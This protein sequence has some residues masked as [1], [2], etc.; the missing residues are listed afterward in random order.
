MTTY[1]RAELLLSVFLVALGVAAVILA[2]YTIGELAV[3]RDRIGA[4]GFAYVAGTLL[5]IGG[6]A[7]VVTQ[8]M[9]S[10]AA[11]AGAPIGK[12]E[13]GGDDPAYP[14]SSLRV[15]A[16]VAG[17]VAYALLL[18]PLGYILSTMLFVSIGTVAMGGR[19]LSRLLVYPFIYAAATYLLFDTLL[20]V[21]IPDGVLR[22]LIVAIGL[23]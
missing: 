2:H 19:G 5:A 4:R 1:R 18:T 16:L 10:R 11:T 6:G 20:G 12:E 14:A 21:R 8:L 9:A 3:L 22:P 23:G 13:L 17:L 7:L 15:F